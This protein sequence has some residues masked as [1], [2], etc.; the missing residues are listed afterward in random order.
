M[1]KPFVSA[2]VAAAENNAIGKDNK[3]LWHLPND[4]RYFKRTT[5]GHA[6]I[7]GRKTYESVGMPLPNR[8][9]LVV[10]RQE[11]YTLE[12]AQVVHSLEAA[13]AHCTN[14]KEVFIVGGAEIYRLALPL[15]DRVYLTRVHANF[16]GDT[17]FPDLD[18]HDWVLVSED[19]H[20]PDE[21]HAYGYTFEVYER[22]NYDTR[23]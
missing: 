1:D 13:L 10:T 12:D 22:R 2:I 8:R 21:R 20:D 15:T 19:K 14:E 7:M 5:S 11:D 6:V 3:L 23:V 18:E 17:Y 9:N 4:L 16:P